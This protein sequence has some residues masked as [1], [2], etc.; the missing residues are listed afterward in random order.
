MSE[1]LKTRAQAALKGIT[2]GP[3]RAC[4]APKG[5]GQR[6][7]NKDGVPLFVNERPGQTRAKIDAEFIAAAPT[8]VRELLTALEA[9]ELSTGVASGLYRSAES[10]VTHIMAAITELV[11]HGDL[12]PA[13]KRKLQQILGGGS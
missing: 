9:T 13:G 2:P 5:R 12:T 3:W 11:H 8:L 6:V 7:T 4:P 1:D 10:D